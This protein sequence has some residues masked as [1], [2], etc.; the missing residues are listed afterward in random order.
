MTELYVVLEFYEDGSSDW[1]LET[2]AYGIFNN[3]EEAEQFIEW[4]MDCDEG[5]LVREDLLIVKITPAT[6]HGLL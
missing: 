4:R 1:L 3:R 5:V 2:D 6:R